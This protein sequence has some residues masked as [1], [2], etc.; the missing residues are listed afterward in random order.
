MSKPQGRKSGQQP[1]TA[2]A[3]APRSN[4]VV[5]ALLTVAV[6]AVFR[7]LFGYDFVDLDDFTYVVNNPHVVARLTLRGTAWAFTHAHEGYWA[8]LTWLSYMADAQFF[9]LN[10][11]AFHATNVVLHAASAC[12]LFA[13]LR[14]MTG[15]Y[16][17]SAFVAALF[18]VHPLHV[19]SVAWIA[20]RKDVLSTFFCFLAIYL[21][22]IFL[23]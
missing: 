19:E 13:A 17:T 8:P 3:Q 23:R 11:A 10:A 2:G 5:Y 6:L 7:Q 4:L 22:Y 16:W 12:L 14:R 9:G 15:A 21:R 18:A 1:R 20:E